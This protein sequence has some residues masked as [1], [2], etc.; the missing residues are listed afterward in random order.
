MGNNKK[1]D[2]LRNKQVFT[3][4]TNEIENMT[5]KLS[6]EINAYLKVFLPFNT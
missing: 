2:N 1:F 6:K 3:K 5:M 4:N